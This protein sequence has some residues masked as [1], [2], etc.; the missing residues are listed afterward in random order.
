MRSTRGRLRE[1]SKPLADED[2]AIATPGTPPARWP[3]A[4]AQRRRT[5]GTPPTRCCM[6][7]R[8]TPR[9]CEPG[10][11]VAPWR[12]KTLSDV[13]VAVPAQETRQESACGTL[14]DGAFHKHF[15]EALTHTHTLTHTY[16][17]RPRNGRGKAST[18]G[19]Q[20]QSN[21]GTAEAELKRSRSHDKKP[22]VH[23]GYRPLSDGNSLNAPS[24][25]RPAVAPPPTCSCFRTFQ[26][27]SLPPRPQARYAQHGHRQLRRLQGRRIYSRSSYTRARGRRGRRGRH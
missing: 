5:P 14:S 20:R 24:S 18:K 23:K 15:L 7:A 27:T 9:G 26:C 11:C 12:R 16:E 17:S 8:G 22:C 6:Y 10:P 3:Q 13:R 4:V 21:Q 25:M 1:R 2:A 19:W